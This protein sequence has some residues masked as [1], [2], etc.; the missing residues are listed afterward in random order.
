MAGSDQSSKA[1]AAF[2]C[3]LLKPLAPEQLAWSSLV[4]TD[5]ATVTMTAQEAALLKAEP[6]T[7]ASKQNDPLWRE[8]TLHKALQPELDAVVTRFAGQGGQKTGFEATANQ[9]LFLINGPNIEKWLKPQNGVLTDRLQK[10]DSSTELAEE[11]YVSVLSRRPSED[12]TAAV[13][14]Y[15]E[16]VSDRATAIREMTWALLSSVEF[17]FNH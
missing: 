15:L 1:A 12:E 3:G 5:Y 11:L 6:E 10:L 16:S 8:E 13:T 14:S 2:A 17:R 9:A 7:A 4:A